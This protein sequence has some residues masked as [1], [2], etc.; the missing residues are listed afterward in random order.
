MKKE[1][2]NQEP[3]TPALRVGAVSGML[4]LSERAREKLDYINGHSIAR[5]FPNTPPDLQ[6]CGAVLDLLEELGLGNYR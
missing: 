2:N 1:Q 6:W 5:N 4:P 3:Q